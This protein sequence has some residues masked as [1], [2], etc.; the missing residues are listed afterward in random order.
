MNSRADGNMKNFPCHRQTNKWWGF[1]SL[2]KTLRW[3]YYSL[4]VARS[5]VEGSPALFSLG[6]G[7][8]RT[9]SR[10]A[11]G[12]KEE[13]SWFQQPWQLKSS[14]AATAEQGWGYSHWLIPHHLLPCMCRT[15]SSS[16][17]CSS[18][19]STPW[20]VCAGRDEHQQ[21]Q[22][23]SPFASRFLSEHHP[24]ISIN[25]NRLVPLSRIP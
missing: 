23:R 6:L 25:L 15:P 19:N 11:C 14:S 21:P 17:S 5:P 10:D 3:N 2:R 1:L 8:I 18:K 4:V 20:C 12:R 7:Q 16:P 13:W 9:K 24:R 22:Q